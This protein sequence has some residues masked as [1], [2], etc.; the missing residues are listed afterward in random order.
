MHFLARVDYPH[1]SWACITCRILSLKFV[2]ELA[3]RMNCWRGLLTGPEKFPTPHLPQ[4]LVCNRQN[5]FSSI[6]KLSMASDMSPIAII[7]TRN[8]AEHGMSRKKKYSLG[9]SLKGALTPRV[10]KYRVRF[11]CNAGKPQAHGRTFMFGSVWTA[12]QHRQSRG[13]AAFFFN[14]KALNNFNYALAQ[15]SRGS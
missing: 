14:F 11:P 7:T 8:W 9:R 13:F 3:E 4:N 6:L 2:T 1:I 10:W 12:L 5:K 15:F